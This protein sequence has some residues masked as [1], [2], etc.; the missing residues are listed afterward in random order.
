M[1][2]VDVYEWIFIRRYSELFDINIAIVFE[3]LN[4]ARE[5]YICGWISICW[6]ARLC[7]YDMTYHNV[8]QISHI[9]QSTQTHTRI[10]NVLLSKGCHFNRFKF[11]IIYFYYRF[12]FSFG[13]SYLLSWDLCTIQ[14]E[15]ANEKRN[16]LNAW[17][18]K[19]ISRCVD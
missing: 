19:R 1:N 12:R 4:D 15:N 18:N 9:N 10:Y 5:L 13:Q 11:T 14:K 7:E 3:N 2:T 17:T 8:Y 16:M 6:K